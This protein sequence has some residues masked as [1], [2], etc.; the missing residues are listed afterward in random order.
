VRSGL[1]EDTYQIVLDR[2]PGLSVEVETPFRSVNPLPN[3][4][5]NLV[6]AVIL[7]KLDAECLFG[8]SVYIHLA[9]K[10]VG[11]TRPKIGD[12]PTLTPMKKIPK[13]P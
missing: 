2:F 1:A 7:N 6:F 11:V 9:I 8:L 4:L 5:P 13:T 12:S 3:V 10:T